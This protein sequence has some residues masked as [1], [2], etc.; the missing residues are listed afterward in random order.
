LLSPCIVSIGTSFPHLG[1]LKA[2]GDV[3]ANER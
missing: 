1:F 3:L 2:S